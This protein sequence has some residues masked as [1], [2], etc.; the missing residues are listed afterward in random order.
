MATGL[1][2]LAHVKQEGAI[3]SRR[4]G[5]VPLVRGGPQEARQGNK[6]GDHREQTR[7]AER[8]IFS[9]NDSD[10]SFQKHGRLRYASLLSDYYIFS[11]QGASEVN[12]FISC[13]IRKSSP[14]AAY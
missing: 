9:A 4:V 8:V 14:A 7:A 5:C 3:H 13:Q 1:G 11:T 2:A 6:A 12:F 10:P